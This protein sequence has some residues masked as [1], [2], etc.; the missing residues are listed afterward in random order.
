MGEAE[1]TGQAPRSSND[2]AS[3]DAAESA[4]E[5]GSEAQA[6]SGQPGSSTGGGGVQPDV[7]GQG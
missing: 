6:P 5:Q 4:V 1:G 7:K 2:P 3:A